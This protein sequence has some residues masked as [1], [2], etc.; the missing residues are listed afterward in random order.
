MAD[1]AGGCGGDSTQ[2]LQLRSLPALTSYPCQRSDGAGDAK[3]AS[4]TFFRRAVTLADVEAALAFDSEFCIALEGPIPRMARLW[5]QARQYGAV[6]LRL[7]W[8]L[9]PLSVASG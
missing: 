5:Q 7:I 3:N 8:P 1:G 6:V 9:G 2:L 4:G